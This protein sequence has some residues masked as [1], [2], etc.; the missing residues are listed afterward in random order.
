MSPLVFFVIII[1]IDL[2]LKSSKDKKKIEEVRKKR[3]EGYKRQFTEKKRDLI[4][5]LNEEIEKNLGNRNTVKENRANKIKRVEK[6]NL[7]LIKANREN[8]IEE[9]TAEDNNRE[10]EKSKSMDTSEIDI[11]K[12]IVRGIIFSEILSEPKSRQHMKRSM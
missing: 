2:I 1:V 6:D 11:R 12:D 7:D 4:T 9:K 5:V 10:V 8:I 3:N